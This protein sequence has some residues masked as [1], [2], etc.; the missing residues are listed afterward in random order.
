MRFK[1]GSLNVNGINAFSRTRK[2]TGD[3][4]IGGLAMDEFFYM[5]APD[6]LCLQ[7]TKGDI[8]RVNSCLRN[9]IK[10]FNY[11]PFVSHSK[12]KSGYAGVAMLI[13]TDLLNQCKSEGTVEVIGDELVDMLDADIDQE[14]RDRF[15]YYSTGRIVRF[16][17]PKFV[18]ISVYTLNSGGKDDLRKV[19]DELFL[20]YIR[21]LELNGR[22]LYILGD[23]NVCHTNLDMWNW[24]ES[25]NTYPGL[26]QYE[27]DG[28]SK[29]LSECNLTDTFRNLNPNLRSYTWSAPKVPL[30]K[31]WRL[32]Y[33]LTDTPNS[34]TLSDIQSNPRVSD[35]VY[36]E[37]EVNI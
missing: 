2:S 21:N 25:I 35:H 30:S 15:K 17:S 8:N 28:F 12:T 5:N 19:W 33:A 23:F 31:G 11:T 26:M 1:I 4:N 16:E 20:R 18:V 32:D 10:C 9:Y 14:F 37:I 3:I 36:I 7:E 22:K 27:I 29:L 6:I 24:E 13:K 34:V